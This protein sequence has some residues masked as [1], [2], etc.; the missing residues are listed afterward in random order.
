LI[1]FSR[2]GVLG[3]I[4]GIII[5]LYFYSTSSTQLKSKY[6]IPTI[7]KYVLPTIISLGS[8]WFVANE[9]TGGML[10]YR[11][12]GE[13]ASTL[14]GYKEKDI[15]TF[16]SGRGEIAGQEIRIW[17]NYFVFGAGLGSS[18]S[19]RSTLEYGGHGGAPHVEA[20]RLLA[21]HG[22]MG[23]IYFILLLGIGFKL[24]KRNTNPKYQSILFVLFIL[25]I[26]TT[27]HAAMRTYVTPLFISLSLLSINQ[28]NEPENLD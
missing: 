12:T 11:Y 20:S 6:G 28:I 14:A 17:G 1:T 24:Y 26:Y 10:Y 7:A 19:L 2:G 13:T 5:I 16:T 23:L 27:F 21:E 25:A 4:L 15:D 22:L 18:S 9:I 3:A 8:I